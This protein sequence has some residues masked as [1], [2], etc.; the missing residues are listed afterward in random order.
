MNNVDQADQLRGS[1][2]FDRWMRKRK[3]WWSMWMWGVQVLLVNSYILYKTAHLLIW[4]PPPKNVLSQ[5]DFRH[6][7]VLRWFEVDRQNVSDTNSG[8]KR[9]RPDAAS[10][11]GSCTSSVQTGINFKRATCVTDKSLDPITGSRRERLD[12]YPEH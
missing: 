11:S 7:I 9:K 5:Y 2:R 4:K 6:A 10:V 12:E 3:W 8:C 1:Y